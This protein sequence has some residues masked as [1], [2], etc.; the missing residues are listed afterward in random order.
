MTLRVGFLGAGQLG[1]PMVRRLIGT[2]HQVSVFARHGDVRAR[3]RDEG[4]TMADS[5]AELA[6][7]SDILISCLYSDAQLREIGL[8]PDGFIANAK[9]GSVFVSNTTGTVATLTELSKS[10]SSPPA[11]VDAPVSGTAEH[12]AEGQLTVL[13]GGARGCGAA[14]ATGPC[15]LRRPHHGHRR[16]R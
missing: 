6:S 2:G 15:S 14:G 13:I 1:E 5:V 12:M 10:S 7:R 11:I 8:G 16:T 9:P 3:L 4:T